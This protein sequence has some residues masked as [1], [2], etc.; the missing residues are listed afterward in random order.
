MYHHLL[1][2][3][4]K[5]DAVFDVLYV[6]NKPLNAYEIKNHIANINL[7]IT[8]VY[9]ILNIFLENKI[10]HYVPYVNGYLICSNPDKKNNHQFL[11]CKKCF[12]TIEYI[13]DNCCTNL[14]KELAMK[15]DF[16]CHYHINETIGICK[17]C[18][19]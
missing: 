19:I 9:R 17:K 5:R 8:T 12:I 11:V 3:T 7:N 10:I 15:N 1:K 14:T 18:Q 2:R 16:L 13:E 6:S 4:K